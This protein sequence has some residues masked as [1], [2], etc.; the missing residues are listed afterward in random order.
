MEKEGA[1]TVP[2]AHND[3]KRQLTAVL[4]VTAAGGYLPQ[5]LLYQGKM[6]KC[7][8]QVAFPDGWDVWHSE[9]HWSN[10]ITMKSYIEKVIVPFVTKKRQK[11]KMDLV[12]PAAAI[13]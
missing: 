12:S 1:K 2:I 8:P 4:A 6:P 13:F 9:Y 3:D 5:Q 10:E 7:H 11:L